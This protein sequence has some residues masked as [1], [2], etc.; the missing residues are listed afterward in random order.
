MDGLKLTLQS[1]GNCKV[2]ER[3]Y[4]GWTHDHYVN[5]VLVFAPDGTIVVC[6]INIPGCC[7]D[8]QIA[9]MG[10]IYQ[11]LE[12]QFDLHGGKCVVDSAF[13]RKGKSNYQKFLIQSSENLDPEDDYLDSCLNIIVN[14]Q[15]TSMR[16]SAEWGMRALK[17]S[18]PRIKDRFI[19]EEHG[20]RKLILQMII[21]L[22]NYRARTV[23]INQIRNFYMPSLNKDVASLFED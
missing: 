22:Y 20:E 10:G 18:F 12:N 5:S 2:Q 21:L 11:K 8:S 7:H 17:A 4:N 9:H 1:S 3:F 14:E 19:F 23:G 6:A 16:Q 13:C 15:A